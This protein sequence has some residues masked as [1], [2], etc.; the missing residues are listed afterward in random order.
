MSNME[1]NFLNEKR[2]R[3]KGDSLE[4]IEKEM[5]SSKSKTPKLEQPKTDNNNTNIINLPNDTNN[6]DK[7]D[8][9]E[10]VFKY[11]SINTNIKCKICQKDI[12]NNIKFY[13]NI[14]PDFI[15]CIKCF[16]SSKHPKSH[17]YHI[18]D[19]LNFPFYTDDW[20]VNDEHKLISNI[21]K[22]GLN[23]W[24]EVSKLMNNKGQVECESHYYSFFNINKNN[25]I[26]DENEIILDDRKNLKHAQIEINKNKNNEMIKF[27][28]SNPGK[29]TV[30]NEKR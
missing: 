11:N 28:S 23:N 27:Y 20:T 5:D 7:V 19:N 15:Y 18:I 16:I 13:C 14:C 2:Q 29:S 22:C 12:T 1:I 4:E 26:P 25:H 9:S 30:E 8:I 6:L 24:E 21:S 3:E 17:E 10:L